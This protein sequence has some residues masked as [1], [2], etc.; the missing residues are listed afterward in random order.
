MIIGHF[1]DVNKKI[2]AIFI[3]FL[4]VIDILPFSH[5]AKILN[6]NYAKHQK[7]GCQHCEV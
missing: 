6:I 1:V 3:E 4:N 5:Q 2:Q 7:K